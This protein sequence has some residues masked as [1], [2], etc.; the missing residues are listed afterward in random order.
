M[1]RY[2]L[3]RSNPGGGDHKRYATTGE[4]EPKAKKKQKTRKIIIIIKI[5][6]SIGK[7][8][9]HQYQGKSALNRMERGPAQ[10]HR[11]PDEFHRGVGATGI[12]AVEL[13]SVNIPT[14]RQHQA[15]AQSD[16][17]AISCSRG[18]CSNLYV[19]MRSAGSANMSLHLPAESPNGR[20]VGTSTSPR[21]AVSPLLEV[22]RPHC[23]LK[24]DYCTA[25]L[26]DH[27]KHLSK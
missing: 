3:R 4:S 23:T 13:R 5:K 17:C 2:N 25:F 24:C 11:F 14:R 10:T 9:S 15:G 21:R 8:Q 18:L 16:R 12:L 22:R 1:S 6:G 26:E 19:R 27:F 20:E 7:A